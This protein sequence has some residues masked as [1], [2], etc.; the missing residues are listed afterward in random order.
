VIFVL[1]YIVI[2][3]LGILAAATIFALW[4]FCWVII[5]IISFIWVIFDDH[6]QIKRLPR[7]R[8]A[9]FSARR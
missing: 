9:Y 2:W 4:A 8:Q 6:R 5:F 1:F 7:P 3:A